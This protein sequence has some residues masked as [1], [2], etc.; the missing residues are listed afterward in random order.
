MGHAAARRNF[1]MSVG[2]VTFIPF[3]GSMGGGSTAHEEFAGSTDKDG[4]HIRPS[5]F[6]DSIIA[7]AGPAFATG[8]ALIPFCY[9]LAFDAQ[10]GFAL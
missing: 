3:L 1:G 9:G 8:A 4:N 10:V 6:R 2:P 5:A 7:V